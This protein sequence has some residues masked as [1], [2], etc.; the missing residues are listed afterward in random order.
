MVLQ[1]SDLGRP[2]NRWSFN[3][4]GPDSFVF[5]DEGG[6]TWKLLVCSAFILHGRH[7][8]AQHAADNPVTAADDAFG[9]TLGLESI[10]MYRPGQVR[11]FSLRTA[12]SFGWKVCISTNREASQIV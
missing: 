2:Q 9:L 10:G 12:G 6:E 7:A 5:R 8:M 1:T 3:P 4:T 11:G